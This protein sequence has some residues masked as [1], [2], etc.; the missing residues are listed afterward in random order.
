MIFQILDQVVND[1][2]DLLF[3]GVR[4]EVPFPRQKAHR[5]VAADATVAN[6][7]LDLNVWKLTAIALC[8]L[9]QVGSRLLESVGEHTRRATGAMA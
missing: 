9:S 3:A 4:P 2:V 8:D 7:L 5:S 1:L 6:Y